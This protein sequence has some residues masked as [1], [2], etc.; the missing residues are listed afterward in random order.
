MSDLEEELPRKLHAS[1]A[2]DD[3]PICQYCRHPAAPD[4]LA[5]PLCG[6]PVDIRVTGSGWMEQPMIQ[7][8]TRIQCGKTR[9]QIAGTLT[10]AAEF[11]LAPDDWVYFAP[12]ALLWADTA[13]TLAVAPVPPSYDPAARSGHDP[14]PAD[15]PRQLLEGHGPGRAA[16]VP[17]TGAIPAA[18][19]RSGF[20]SPARAGWPCSL[21]TSER[22]R[23]ASPITSPSPPPSDGDPDATFRRR[24]GRVHRC[25]PAIALAR[26]DHSLERC[27][28]V[29]HLLTCFPADHQRHQDL[30]D[31]VTGEVDADGQPGAGVGKRLD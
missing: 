27:H 23:P 31:A 14:H 15:M 19:G 29:R 10:P 26:F 16:R 12:H 22:R 11:A 2:E 17:G 30:A 13:T 5:C 6:A 1:P 18:T 9:C 20:D 4:S 28:I 25:A 3:S 21:F 7:S 24:S 8:M